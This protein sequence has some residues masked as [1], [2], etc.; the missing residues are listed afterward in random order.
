MYGEGKRRGR[1]GSTGMERESMERQGKVQHKTGKNMI[2][3]FLQVRKQ[4][5]TNSNKKRLKKWAM[6]A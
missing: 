6:K 3:L 4:K 2:S 5:Q 1:K